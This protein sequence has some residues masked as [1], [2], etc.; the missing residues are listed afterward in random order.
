[1]GLERVDPPSKPK[2]RYRVYYLDQNLAS[3]TKSFVHRDVAVSF[4]R[5]WTRYR[6]LDRWTMKTIE[7]KE[8]SARG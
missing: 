5:Y 1:M 8:N 7:K 3:H 4:A 6:I 2:R